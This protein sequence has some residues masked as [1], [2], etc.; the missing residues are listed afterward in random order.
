MGFQIEPAR[1]TRPL[2]DDF[3]SAID[4]YI[5]PLQYI[6][7]V[8]FGYQL[9]QWQVDILRHALELKDG[10]LRH[11][12]YLVSMPR[13]NGKSELMTALAV[14][15]LLS[16][17]HSL[18]I[19]IASSAEQARIVYDRTKQTIDG[20]PALTKRFTAL[21]DTR[22][23]RTKE[24]GR[25]EVKG[26]KGAALQGLAIALGIVDEV[27]LLSFDLWNALVN[28]TGGRDNAIVIGITTAGDDNSE[29]L[30]H[31][32]ELG[33]AGT[34]G[35]CIYES[36]QAFIPKDDKQLAELLTIANPAVACGR[37]KVEALIEIVRS[38]PDQDSIRYNLNRF[39]TGTDST[40]LPVEV[41]LANGTAPF[42]EGRMFVT[43][44]VTPDQAYASMTRSI[45]K[46]NI[47]YTELIASIPN[48]TVDTLER[49]CRWL[50]KYRCTFVMDFK[51]LADRLTKTGYPV[52]V[53]NGAGVMA[54]SAT[55]YAKA[56]QNK[57]RHAND[58]L[59]I[60]QFGNTVRKTV[61]D[62][63]KAYRRGTNPIDAVRATIFGVYAAETFEDIKPVLV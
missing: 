8:A 50:Y 3:E 5:K 37:I 51:P 39:V 23:L 36:P 11:R 57:I 18:V 2:A 47:L 21:T 25:Y 9:D 28:G 1:Y 7:T 4:P 35:Y 62:G 45:K 63:F 6:W 24:G 61:G 58:P 16:N 53:I 59:V 43:V 40:F 26:A 33:D 44:D 56:V 14:W 31:L 15:R 30:K 19:G 42:P 41:W 46:D 34:Q 55:F 29:L 10:K 38:K 12:T 54:A 27:H 49:M 20:L 22:G 52:K 48:P 13:Q 60:A 32:Y 17:P